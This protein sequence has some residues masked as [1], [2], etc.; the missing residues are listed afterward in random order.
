MSAQQKYLYQY[1]YLD[2]SNFNAVENNNLYNDERGNAEI[3]QNYN[4][5][6]LNLNFKAGE[7][8]AKALSVLLANSEVGLI[9]EPITHE[10]LVNENIDVYDLVKIGN[11][12]MTPNVH[13][14]EV[15]GEFLSNQINNVEFLTRRII[16]VAQGE[17]DSDINVFATINDG[18]NDYIINA[19]ILTHGIS[20][21]YY[22]TGDEVGAPL[23]LI[24]LRD[25]AAFSIEFNGNSIPANFLSGFVNPACEMTITNAISIM[26]IGDNAFA[27]SEFS[28]IIANF[29]GIRE[30]GSGVQLAKLGG[31]ITTINPLGLIAYDD[32]S[33]AIT[34]EVAEIDGLIIASD[35]FASGSQKLLNDN[36]NALSHFKG[37]L[38]EIKNCTIVDDFADLTNLDMS[39]VIFD[40]CTF[41]V[42]QDFSGNPATRTLA[43]RNCNQKNTGEQTFTFT[44][45][46]GSIIIENSF[47]S[48]EATYV[49]DDAAAYALIIDNYSFINAGVDS[50]SLNKVLSNENRNLTPE[51]GAAS[52]LRINDNNIVSFSGTS[53]LTTSGTVL[54]IT[55]ITS[56]VFSANRKW[57]LQN[58]SFSYANFNL[59]SDIYLYNDS[60]K[61]SY[62]QNFITKSF[63]RF[64][65]GASESFCL[66]ASQLLQI[67]AVDK[68]FTTNNADETSWL[69]LTIYNDLPADFNYLAISRNDNSFIFNAITNIRF[70][71][72]DDDLLKNALKAAYPEYLY[73]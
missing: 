58:G 48:A 16:Y 14:Y 21:F 3:M 45:F 12:N 19:A 66:L 54:T 28:N 18:T 32:L 31:E 50:G 36:C 34:N 55:E 2:G 69:A 42:D 10:D 72:D 51:V 11:V 53:F 63:F 1:A 67:L 61:E 4:H 47:K 8:T 44:G 49:V 68:C 65:H 9:L 73:P 23:A 29:S 22:P 24:D 70:L 41:A 7:H 13:F 46:A 35:F 38:T 64:T 6:S 71:N 62:I 43:I 25:M 60:T 15:G 39:E 52:F 30:L 40:N 26:R 37:T 56:I 17:E 27:N 57:N 33:I 59:S 20:S 5:N